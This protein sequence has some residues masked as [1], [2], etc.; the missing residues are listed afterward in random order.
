MVKGR[1]G[2]ERKRERGRER[3]RNEERM[4]YVSLCFNIIID[5]VF[6][7]FHLFV[8]VCSVLNSIKSW[9]YCEGVSWLS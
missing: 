7:L 9:V 3:G 1:E 6:I 4:K 8:L 5:S 2:E